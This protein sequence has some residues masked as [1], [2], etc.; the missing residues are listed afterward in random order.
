MQLADRTER[1]TTVEQREAYSLSSETRAVSTALLHSNR[2]LK[3]PGTAPHTT[4]IKDHRLTITGYGL[5][6]SRR[7]QTKHPLTA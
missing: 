4:G 1:T 7:D 3:G 2:P 6:A 5:I